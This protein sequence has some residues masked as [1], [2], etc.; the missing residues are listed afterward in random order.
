MHN[1][2]QIKKNY[3]IHISQ[4]FKNILYIHSLGTLFRKEIHKIQEIK[5]HLLFFWV[6]SIK[7]KH[8]MRMRVL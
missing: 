1:K 2:N 5:K 6:K 4:G 8:F 3:K 7:W